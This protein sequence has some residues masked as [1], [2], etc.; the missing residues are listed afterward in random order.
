MIVAL[1]GDD[2]I[3][4]RGGND[5]ICA[6]AGADTIHGG[7]GHD[8]LFGGKD[9]HGY[10]RGGSWQMG[11]TLR[12]GPGS[13]HMDPG[14]DDPSRT[15]QI[16]QRDEIDYRESARGVVANLTTNVVTGE[17]RDTYVDSPNIGLVGS[18]H[19]DVLRGSEQ[20]DYLVG[21]AG[22]DVIFG[23]GGPDEI[24]ADVS[25][26][27]KE[28]PD[29]DAIHGG[30]GADDITSEA[31]RD[32]LHGDAGNDRISTYG[33]EAVEIHAGDGND[34][35]SMY[36]VKAA[37]M[38]ADPGAGDD[39]LTVYAKLPEQQRSRTWLRVDARAGTIRLGQGQIGSFG[40]WDG[41][42]FV[43]DTK[44]SYRGSDIDEE[45]TALDVVVLRAWTLGGDDDIFGTPGDDFLD[46]GEGND[47]IR[48]NGGLDTCL[49][50]ERT[51]G[52]EQ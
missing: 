44:V 40:A 41:V 29:R 8:R 24:Y 12:G 43:P 17:G 33:R 31:G 28:A 32:V 46:A 18:M 6:G 47:R 20:A 52:C 49:N 13:D 1:A 22:E 15:D 25:E 4:G 7:P 30:S 19:D 2:V 34:S 3:R 14:I 50:A 35:A 37:G 38:V 36:A 23:N 45:V 39:D 10:D 42:T 48:A 27:T 11:D 21:M 51:F 26:G 5:L 16:F 9:K